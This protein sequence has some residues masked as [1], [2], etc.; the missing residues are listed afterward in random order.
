MGP[1]MVTL[2]A[3]E[4]Q[5]AEGRTMSERTHVTEV[6]KQPHCDYEAVSL[7]GPMTQQDQRTLGY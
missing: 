7:S 5:E 6:R 1:L 2:F 4:W 3:R